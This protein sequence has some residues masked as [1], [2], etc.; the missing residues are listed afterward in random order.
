M[1]YSGCIQGSENLVYICG[2]INRT[3]DQISKS[4]LIFKPK[5]QVLIHKPDMHDI[6]YTFPLV[7]CKGRL[8]ALGG[9]SFGDDHTSLRNECEYFH[10]D[11][12]EWVKIANMN[13]KRCTSMPFVFKDKVFVL[14]GYSGPSKRTRTLESYNEE[15]D[16]WTVSNILLQQGIEAGHIYSPRPNCIIIYGGKM[17]TGAQSYVHEINLESEKILN[18]T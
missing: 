13:E 7:I 11:R 4:F 9:R 6:R 5:D 15:L 8:Y 2:G 17:E 10:P 16:K 3:L 18:K 1:N 12:Q 14:G